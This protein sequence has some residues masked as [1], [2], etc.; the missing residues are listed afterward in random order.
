[1]K[2]NLDK[3]WFIKL[4]KFSALSIQIVAIILI[5]LFIGNFIDNRINTSPWFLLAFM[6][7]GLAAVIK[8]ILSFIEKKDG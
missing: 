7:I 6:I 3:S 1:M 8:I 2:N 4:G 5:S